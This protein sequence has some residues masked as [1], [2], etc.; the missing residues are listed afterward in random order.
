[1]L[2]RRILAIGVFDLF[3]VGHLR[4]LQYARQQ[5]QHLTVAVCRDAVSSTVK[6]V[7]PVICEEHR[8]EIIRGLACV[9]VANL[10]PCSTKE[11][12]R[13]AIW[14]KEWGIDHVIGGGI[15]EGSQRWNDLTAALAMQGITVSF[16]PHTQ[17]ISTTQIRAAIAGT[18]G[19]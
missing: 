2:E 10:A 14:I 12:A 13:S 19:A 5:G 1:M 4:Y 8:L 17:G 16:A 7:M 9:D 6:E 11:A 3:H 15:W 18:G